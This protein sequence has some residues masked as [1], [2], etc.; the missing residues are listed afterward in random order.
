MPTPTGQLE[1]Q[2][3]IAVSRA[4]RAERAASELE[5]VVATY[6]DTTQRAEAL[7]RVTDERAQM[8]AAAN[9]R[10][11]GEVARLRQELSLYQMTARALAHVT[12]SEQRN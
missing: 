9:L 12:P 7:A 4:D 5:A 8:L 1:A 6:R 10:L 2:L 11:H 3:A